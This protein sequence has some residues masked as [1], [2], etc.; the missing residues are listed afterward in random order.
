LRFDLSRD[1]RRDIWVKR[2]PDGPFSRI[3]FG[4]TSSVRPAWSLDGHEVLYIVDRS[5]SGVGP[6]YTHHADG[7]GAARVVVSSRTV[8]FGQIVPSRNGRW[9]LLR[10][11]TFGSVSA[12][13][14]GLKA[15]DT[16]L[17][18]LVASPAGEFFPSLSPDG[19][20]LAYASNKSGRN[21]VYVRPFPETASAKWQVSIA[22]GTEP[23]WS[24]T[25]RELLYINGNSE[26][27]SAQIPSGATFSV[28]RQR[29]PF[30]VAQFS[31]PGPVPS[32]SLSPDGKR[33]L[34]IREGEASQPSEVIFAEHWVD[35]L[36]AHAG[37]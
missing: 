6:V 13:I 18:P 16:T 23:A 14:V 17:V 25:G 7:T 20:W 29:A 4:D 1:G 10:T 15:G 5:G 12:D 8:D 24:G 2:V 32:F 9:P 3:T 26:M 22:G 27:V 36:R 30:S 33:F 31:L 28:G 34:M 21:E 11:S 19:R 37:N 35:E